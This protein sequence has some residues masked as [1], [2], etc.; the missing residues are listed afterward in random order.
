MKVGY[1][2]PEFPGQTHIWMWREI[3]HM[4]EWGMDVRL[5]STRR[6]G[7]RTRAKHAFAEPAAGETFYV[8][9]QRWWRWLGDLL[10]WSC[11]SPGGLW[12]CLRCAS[13]L[14][15]LSRRDALGLVVAGCVLARRVR[16]DGIEHLHCHTFGKG[17]VLGVFVK[18][19]TGVGYSL[20][21]NAALEGVGGGFGVE[22]GRGGVHDRDHGG[23]FTGCAARSSRA[24]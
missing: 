16:R 21:L 6:P 2:I 10:W 15:G 4:R 22:N 13:R 11:M 5:Y 9:P 1:L 19:L 14:E 12:R 3:L 7:E 23:S 20:T 8:W 18:W 24:G 17:A